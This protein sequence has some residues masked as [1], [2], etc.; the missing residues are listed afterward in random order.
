MENQIEEVWKPI[1]GYEG[2]YEVSNYGRVKSLPKLRKA[3][4]GIRKVRERIMK[5]TLNKTTGYLCV[6]FTI[7]NKTNA[8][9]VHNLVAFAFCSNPEKK[10][11]VNHIDTNK[12]N[13]TAEN[14]E[15]STPLE[16]TRHSL[17]TGC[18]KSLV[19]SVEKVKEIKDMAKMGMTNSQIALV[20]GIQRKMAWRVTTNQIWQ[21]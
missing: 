13:N 12:L 4:Q 3:R 14:L 1:T 7:Y 20:L 8:Q 2:L 19:L 17:K 15:W 11:Q 9:R 18:K 21:L 10:S 16:N 5:L 6:N